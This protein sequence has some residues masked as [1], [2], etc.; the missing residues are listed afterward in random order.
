[1]KRSFLRIVVLI[2][3]DLFLIALATAV[4]FVLRD[5]LEIHAE[6][7]AASLPYL[8]ITLGVATAVLLG[9]GASRA[10]WRYASMPDYIR[11]VVVALAIVGL[12]LTV[13]FSYNR[14]SDV[15][16][17]IP[18]LQWLLIS[19]ALIGSR[20]AYRQYR[21]RRAEVKSL[22]MVRPPAA[23]AVLVVGVN[24]VTELF[25]T[26]IDTYASKHI[27]VVGLLSETKSSAVGRTAYSIPVLGRSSELADVIR[28]LEVHGVEVRQ[29]VVT[30]LLSELDADAKAAIA[31]LEQ[32]T[33]IKVDY[34]SEILDIA[35]R[36]G[37]ARRM[38]QMGARDGLLEGD[39]ST[40]SSPPLSAFHAISSSGQKATGTTLK[41]LFDIVL[42]IILLVSFAPVLV[43]VAILVALEIGTP[44]LFWQYRPGLRKRRFKL[45]KFRTMKAA[46][47]ENGRR[48]PDAERLLRIG[49]LLRRLR[50][51]EL[52]QLFNVIRGDMSFVGP[53]PLLPID[54]KDAPEQRLL[55]RPG[56][57]GWAQINGGRL[58]SD[59][60]K[61]ALDLWY[62]KHQG[63]F[64]DLRI[65]ALTVPMILFGDRANNRWIETAWKELLPPR[66]IDEKCTSQEADMA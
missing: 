35:S 39:R 34:M 58:I 24:R 1:M 51:D 48:L 49:K 6:R 12:T 54:Q 26:C 25:L 31:E 8:I 22:R 21:A 43:V 36:D 9:S 19:V 30:A 53:R 65:M 10:I 33:T 4:A 17:S 64:L 62:V 37:G 20:V 27:N 55:A 18:I 2:L 38:T 50:I 52:P 41:R 56:L 40:V 5:N 32:S 23:E 47:D 45:L 29:V 46:H 28:T 63:F 61:I 59:N 7:A 13:S 42:A 14:M 11:L 15:A 66:Q 44:V 16:R 57:T 3:V 60:D